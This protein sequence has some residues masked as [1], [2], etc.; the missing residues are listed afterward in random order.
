MIYTQETEKKMLFTKQRYYENGSK[1][2]KILA[3]KLKK[4][5]AESTIYKIR[6]SHK[7]TIESKQDKIQGVFETFYKRLYSST[8]VDD[9]QINS[10]LDA[11][12]LPTLTEDQNQVLVS[13]IT[14]SELMQTINKLKTN[15]SPGSDGYPTEWYKAFKKELIPMLLTTCN[16]AL[17]KAETPPTWREAIVSLIPKEGKDKT[18]C[19]SYRPISILNVDYRIFTSIMAR[20]MEEFLPSSYHS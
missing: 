18:E 7:N 20:S 16:W 17:K 1:F 19:G 4:Q 13:E 6:D 11:L 14:E 15:K 2:T 5:Q 9:N 3:R 8:Y 10:F 12:D